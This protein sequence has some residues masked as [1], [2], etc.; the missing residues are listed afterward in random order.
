LCQDGKRPWWGYYNNS[1]K[2]IFFIAG[3]PNYVYVGG[4]SGVGK[5]SAVSALTLRYKSAIDYISSGEIKRPEARKRFGIGLSQLNQE[6][7]YTINSWFLDKLLHDYKDCK[8]DK[9]LLIDSHYKY[10]SG[11][12]FVRIV[13]LGYTF[14]DLLVLFEAEASTVMQRRINRGRDRDSVILSYV[15]KELIEEK[16]EAERLSC[17]IPLEII[18]TEQPLKSVVNNFENILFKHYLI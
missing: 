1:Y 4:V 2:Q 6:Q 10:P 3:V 8:A 14:F 16:L 5:T 11:D 17:C 18:S 15:E 9:T 7:T 13:P 12:S